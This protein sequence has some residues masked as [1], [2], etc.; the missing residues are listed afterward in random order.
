[1]RRPDSQLHL[2]VVSA[3]FV[4]GDVKAGGLVVFRHAETDDVVGDLEEHVACDTGP[5]C[6]DHSG[7]ELQADLVSDR[8]I[9]LVTTEGC[10]TEEPSENRSDEAA[11]TMHAED[12]EGVVVAEC[13]LEGG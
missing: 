10:R 3:L 4:E 5:G 7:E 8:E 13:A 2:E 9:D 6:C 12:V 11:N 1:M